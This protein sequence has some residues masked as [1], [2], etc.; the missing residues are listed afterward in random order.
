MMASALQVK[1]QYSKHD[2][3][4]RKHFI[5]S[6]LFM[7]ANVV[8]DN[9]SPEMVYLNLGYRLTGKDVISLE[10]K[11][12]KYGW[13][14]G[15]P[16]GKS[17]EAEGEGFPGYIRE[18]GVSINYQR[19]FWNGLFAQVDVMPAFQ[20]FVN[21]KGHKI[22]KGFQIFNTY[23]IGYHVKLF[24]DRFFIDPSIAITHR[25]YQSKMPD[26]FQQLDDR[27]PRFFYWQPGLHFG[28]NF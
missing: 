17:Y 2:S 14:I 21:H 28:Y 1:A 8:P 19:F 18:H 7:I 9:N 25:P 16:Y 15:I 5:G 12:W 13:P 26:S 4:Y 24:K 10:F 6:T 3:T 23:S 20:T 27:W 11:T 22:D